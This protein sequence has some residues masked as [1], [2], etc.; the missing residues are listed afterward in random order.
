LRQSDSKSEEWNT[1]ENRRNETDKYRAD[2]CRIDL[3]LGNGA[4]KTEVTIAGPRMHQ[5]M[6]GVADGKESREE[7]QDGEQTCECGN[8]DPLRANTFSSFLQGQPINN[9]TAPSAS[10]KSLRMEFLPDKALLVVNHPAPRLL[11]AKLKECT[12]VGMS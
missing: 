12:V 8:C 3:P 10:P 2:L 5:A 11:F 4:N 6:S 7:Q 1:E 9:V